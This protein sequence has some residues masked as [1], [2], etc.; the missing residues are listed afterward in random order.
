MQSGKNVRGIIIREAGATGVTIA[1]I[2]DHTPSSEARYLRP[3]MFMAQLQ[4]RNEWARR[5]WEAPSEDPN[6]VR[7]QRS[8][9][10]IEDYEAKIDK[11]LKGNLGLFTR[12]T[13]SFV[14]NSPNKGA[15]KQENPEP[16]K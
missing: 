1:L 9:S 6:G 10:E 15:E 13:I 2:T 4:I 8:A 14:G 12:G 16:G 3:G 11:F 5:I 7:A